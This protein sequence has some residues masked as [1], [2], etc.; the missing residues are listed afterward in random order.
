[1][2]TQP[3]TGGGGGDATTDAE[4]AERTAGQ[5]PDPELPWLTI[6]DLG[7]LRRV[8]TAGRDAAVVY[9]SP[10]YSGCPAMAAIE[11]D[12]SEALSRAGWKQVSVR[13]ELAPAWTTD[14]ISEEGRQKLAAAGIA[15]PS[16]AAATAPPSGAGGS[17]PVSLV[18]CPRCGSGSTQLVSRF[19]STAC[20]ALYHCRACLEPFEHMK[21]L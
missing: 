14:W 3:S 15:P 16:G 13:R 11:A 4:A 18:R 7:I 2:V 10:T 6:A 8:E 20:K 17:S 5:V 1:M 21:P 12:V 9:L 19:S